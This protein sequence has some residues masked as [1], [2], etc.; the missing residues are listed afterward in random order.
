MHDHPARMRAA[1]YDV[2]G[3]HRGELR[4]VEVPRP[5]PGPDEVLVRIRQS[6]VNPTD[7]KARLGLSAASFDSGS[8]TPHHDGAGVI[9]EVG[10]GVSPSRI[11]ERVWLH[12]AQWGRR[13]GTA[14]EWVAI[15]A[16][17][18]VPLPDDCSFELG[19]TLGIPAL[20]A[21]AALE[22]GPRDL[23]GRAVL[24]H[25]G[26][27]AVGSVCSLMAS[28]AGATVIATA[29]TPRTHELALR[30]GASAT[31]DYRS[32]QAA[33]ELR[34]YAAG[35]FDLI[36]DVALEENLGLDALVV[37]DEG[38]I[39]SYQQPRKAL[40]LPRELAL[41]NASIRSLNVF[42]LKERSIGAGVAQIQD[43]LRAGRM[44]EPSVLRFGLD[45]VESAHRAV[46]D[47]THGTRVLVDPSA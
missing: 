47:G 44:P 36:V 38:T 28:R 2:S 13:S 12:R 25:G 8:V 41:R 24:V 23:Q 11:G 7:W 32:A 18:A 27:G 42:T 15:R 39:V 46:R 16:V 5:L 19:A 3:A 35:G 22:A 9:E 21:A 37:S 26:A 30:W 6:G 31:V 14:A 20:T 4:L 29:G 40:E 45:E 1:L 33:A 34:E 43:L 10:D 17:L